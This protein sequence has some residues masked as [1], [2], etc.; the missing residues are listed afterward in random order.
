MIS[1]EKI[2]MLSLLTKGMLY[3]HC[4]TLIMNNRNAKVV[5]LAGRW[6]STETA[7]KMISLAA[8]LPRLNESQFPYQNNIV[9]LT[10]ILDLLTDC[11][12]LDKLIIITETVN[13]DYWPVDKA[14]DTLVAL[15]PTN[16]ETSFQKTPNGS[17]LS[18][19]RLVFKKNVQ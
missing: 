14:Y 7:T 1:S 9:Q 17:Y 16:W 11:K 4:L 8:I 10:S 18:N 13:R 15:S 5:K 3:D 6:S 12:A 2:E 19:Y